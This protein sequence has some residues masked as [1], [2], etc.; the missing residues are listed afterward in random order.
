MITKV[1]KRSIIGLVVL[2][3]AGGFFL[4]GDMLSYVSSGV[5]GVRDSVKNAIPVDIELYRARDLLVDIQ[6]EIDANKM[7]II[8]E[9]VKIA[10]LNEKIDNS[11]VSLTAEKRRIDKLRNTLAS[12]FASYEIGRHTY[13]RTEL[14]DDLNRRFELYKKARQNFDVNM[15]LL[16]QREKYLSAARKQLDAIRT[17]RAELELKIEGLE[18]QHRLV[19][20]TATNSGIVLN[21][22]KLSQTE[23]LL[24]EIKFRL[25]VTE[26]K[27]ASE[28]EFTQPLDLDEPVVSEVD[29]FQ[30]LDDYFNTDTKAEIVINEEYETGKR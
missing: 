4:G 14:L 7:L 21:D 3:A 28:G 6:P 30:S 13:T 10:A 20:A 11:E 5:N 19:Q 22:S 27:L 17:K 25:D 23:Q 16:S 26:R 9:E 18:T 1:V 8:E 2:G 15:R 24:N 12:E 29:L